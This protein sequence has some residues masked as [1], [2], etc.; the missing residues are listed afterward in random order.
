M[1][2]GEVG[3]LLV[4][5]KVPGIISTEY[6]GMPEKTIESRRDLWFHTGDFAR[7]DADG[8]YYFMSRHKDRIRRRGENVSP[9][10][11]ESILC[12]HPEIVDCAALAHPAQEG[13][14]DIR[15]VLVAKA[16]AAPTP[17]AVMDWL[18]GRMPV[19]MMPRYIEFALALPRNP[20]GKVEKYKLLEAGLAAHA[21][22]RQAQ[23]YVLQRDAKP[24]P[25]SEPEPTFKDTP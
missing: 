6:L 3:E 25:V 15:V 24:Q 17:R 20:V 5:H 10:E 21:W 19:F 8:Y 23:G 22:D 7:R 9:L 16:G 1:P 13:E 18:A 12:R 2:E 14:D 4:R 11:V